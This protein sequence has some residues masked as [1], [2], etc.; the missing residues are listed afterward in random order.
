MRF[1]NKFFKIIFIAFIFLSVNVLTGCAASNKKSLSAGQKNKN[2]VLIIGLS[3]DA[4]NLIGNMAADAPTAEVTSQI[5]DGL[6][7]YN[8]NLKIV[9]DLAKSWK[10]SDGG[11]TITFMLHRNVLWQ[12]GHHFTARDVLFTYRLMVNPNTPTP[13]AAD[14]L[15]VEKASVI[16]KYIF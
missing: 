7:R 9:P 13:Y 12:D 14:Y 4:T 3:A 16:G 8:R 15:K 11:R 2:N 1:K 6:V 5:Y 10:I